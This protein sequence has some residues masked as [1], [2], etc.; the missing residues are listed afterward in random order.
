MFFSM[1]TGFVSDFADISI[2]SRLKLQ[3]YRS[4]GIDVSQDADTGVFK[5]AVIRNPAKRDVNVVNVDDKV[6]RS[7]YANVFWDSL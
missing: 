4:L 5:R 3:V 2:S 7:V 6:D 1:L